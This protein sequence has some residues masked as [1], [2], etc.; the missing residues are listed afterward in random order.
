LPPATIKSKIKS[1]KSKIVKK[2]IILTIL[3]LG[4]GWTLSTQA[5]TI[6]PPLK[7]FVADPGTEFGD[8]IKLINDEGA[9]KTYFATVE[10]FRARGE[11]G[12]PEFFQTTD[13]TQLATWITLEQT[14]VTLK[15][16]EK[17]EIKYTVRVP[18]KASAGGHYAAIFWSSQAPEPTG[19]TG[20]GVVSKIGSLVLVRV[21]GEIKEEMDLIEF[22]T[23]KKVYNRLPVQFSLAFENR[24]NVHL[25]PSG[26]ITILPVIIGMGKGELT[27]NEGGGN[28][29][30]KSIR[31]FEASWQKSVVP[32][33]KAKNIFSRFFEELKNEWKNFA[34]GYFRANLFTLFGQNPPQVVQKSIFFLVFPWR[35]I[36]MAVILAAI[37]IWLLIKGVKAYNRWIIKKYQIS[38]IKYQK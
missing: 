18:E 35:V 3:L 38:N 30:P 7:E 8:V 31:R 28:V 13:E 9:E 15:P 34:L 2:I 37:I 12:E 32:E 11:K 23:P 5:L 33:S 36:L 10:G 25:K 29:L 19:I 24:G 6:S 26:E 27:V 21:S 4:I 17:K 1:Q 22:S 14:S 20:V 16:R